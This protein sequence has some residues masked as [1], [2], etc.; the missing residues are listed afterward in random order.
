MSSQPIITREEFIARSR[1]AQKKLNRAA[2]AG[3]AWLLGGM[4]LA[5][6]ILPPELHDEPVLND[7]RSALLFLGHIVSSFL[8]LTWGITTLNR[9]VGICCFA[10]NKCITGSQI[11]IATGNCG[12]CGT[13]VLSHPSAHGSTTCTC[14]PLH[15]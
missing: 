15:S 14:Q 12:H 10:C 8:L 13:Q 4:L 6:L 5:M 11:V 3:L 2:I 1:E 9:R 7:Y